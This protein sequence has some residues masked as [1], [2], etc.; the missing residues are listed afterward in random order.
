MRTGTYTKNLVYAFI[1]SSD[2]YYLTS[3]EILAVKRAF[4]LC[5]GMRVVW[6]GKSCGIQ[7]TINHL[8]CDYV[9]MK[10]SRTMAFANETCE[11]NDTHGKGK[12]TSYGKGQEHKIP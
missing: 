9:G 2:N 12:R 8:T 4:H 7:A 11:L 6:M 3:H 10:D 5:F 1:M